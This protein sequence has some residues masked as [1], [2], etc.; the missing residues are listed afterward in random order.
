MASDAPFGLN[1]CMLIGEWTLLV[2]VTLNTSRVCAGGQSRLFEFKTTVRI[3]AIAALHGSFENLMV[4]GP[5]EIGL[6]F[7]MATH[8]KLRLAYFQHSDRGEAGLFS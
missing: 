2:N 7:T 5:G 1:R 4:E 8:T 6:R 3:M